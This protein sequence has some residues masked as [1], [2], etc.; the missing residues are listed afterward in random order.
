MRGSSRRTEE[1]AREMRRQPTRAEARIWHWLRGRRWC[2]Y[3]FR[4]QVPF[5]RYIVDFYCA[6]LRL[7]IEVDGNQHADPG[8]G[9]L[10]FERMLELRGLG[11][12]I[13]R[14]TNLQLIRDPR[15]AGE[16]I[17]AAIDLRRRALGL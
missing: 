2:G 9:E 7:A 16:Q 5:G 13:F 4:R 15:M 6:E 12:E 3:K 14:V 17:R 8:V 11:I 10:D 1:Y